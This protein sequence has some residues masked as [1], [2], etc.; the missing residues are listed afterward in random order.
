MECMFDGQDKVNGKMLNYRVWPTL[1]NPWM[2]QAGPDKL[3]VTDGKT[4]RVYDFVNW[5]IVD[6]K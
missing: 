4:T 2:S 6:S 3:T 1:E 5:K